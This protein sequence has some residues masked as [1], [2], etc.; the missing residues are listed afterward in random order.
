MIWCAVGERSHALGH[1]DLRRRGHD[2]DTEVLR[3]RQ[4][5][6]DVGVRHAS[7][8]SCCSR[9]I[10]GRC[11][12]FSKIR[13]TGAHVSGGRRAAARRAARPPSPG[14]TGAPAS[15]SAWFDI[16]STSP[17]PIETMALTMACASVKR[18]EAVGDRARSARRGSANRSRAAV[19][20]AGRR[21]TPMPQ[22]PPSAILPNSRR[23]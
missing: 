6:L 8:R 21:A 22:A 13:R 1:A 11:P 20:A 3:H 19:E 18:A 14:P 10:A 12:P 9:A 16:S 23:V 5:V 7:S 2:L 4:P 17:R 15:A